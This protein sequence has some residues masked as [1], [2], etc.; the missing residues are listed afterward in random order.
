MT[1]RLDALRALEKAVADGAFIGLGGRKSYSRL[2]DSCRVAA[3]ANDETP[4]AMGALHQSNDQLVDFVRS[5]IEKEEAKCH[6]P[7]E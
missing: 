1:N 7:T 2:Y 5:L 3:L 6:A 4:G